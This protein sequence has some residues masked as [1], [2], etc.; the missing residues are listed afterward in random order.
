[1]NNNK[2]AL[3]EA[4]EY[5]R[6][7]K[8]IDDYILKH[9]TTYP[10]SSLITYLYKYRILE[11]FGYDLEDI[12]MEVY[13]SIL[14]M[15]ANNKIIPNMPNFIK[16]KIMDC[17]KDDFID[18]NQNKLMELNIEDFQYLEINHQE[19]D[20]DKEEIDNTFELRIENFTDRDVIDYMFN[21]ADL[22][23]AERI[24]LIKYYY[25]EKP[26]SQLSKELNYS[27]SYGRDIIYKAL[28]KI[29]KIFLKKKNDILY[30]RE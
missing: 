12:F 5:L 30:P 29:R 9:G 28:T 24:A 21:E 19:Y 20:L 10:V 15:S 27:K 26:A 13:V 17:I 23:D 18:T 14:V 6:K 3:D 7:Y 11:S 1:M 2:K 22:R 8:G 4:T 25:E 16:R